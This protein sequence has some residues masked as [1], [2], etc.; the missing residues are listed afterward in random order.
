M[1]TNLFF[2]VFLVIIICS[3]SFLISVSHSDGEVEYN[4][5]S[6][7][8]K[9]PENWGK[10]KPEWKLCGIGKLQSPID[11]L[12]NM[13]QELPEL[14][15]LEKNYKSAPAALKNR[16]HDVKLV[17]NG[18]AGKFDIKGISYKLVNCHWHIPAEH[19]LNG[20]KFDMEL[21]AVHQNSKGEIAVIGIWY[22]IG[23]QDSFLSKLLEKIKLIGDKDMDIGK[24]N[25]KEIKFGSKHYYRYIGSLTTPPCT[26]GVIW[27]VLQKVRT[28]SS[29]QLKVLKE[30]VHPGFEENARPTQ[31]LGEKQ[32]FSYNSKKKVVQE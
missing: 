13:V 2:V 5:K 18:D 24:I 31:D 15:K 1:I 3:S 14:G 27:T 10:I 9:G 28:V 23:G 25:P 26:E 32:V 20:T 4:Y 30:A 17:W 7:D 29:E 22:K 16:S 11:I 8:S 12:N 19:T 6:G 21:H